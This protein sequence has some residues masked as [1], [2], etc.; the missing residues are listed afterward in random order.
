MTELAVKINRLREEYSV[1]FRKFATDCL[2]IRTKTQGVKPFILNEVQIDF[3]NRFEKQLSQRKKGRFIILKARQMGLSTLIEAIVYWRTIYH[4]GV[5]SLVLTHLDS[6]TKELFEITRRYHTSIPNEMKPKAS[7]DSANEL[8]FKGLDSAIK[9]ATAGNK[10]VGHGSTFQILHWSEVS[11]SR[12]QSDIVAGVLQA[13]PDGDGSIVF[14]ESTANG[15][16]DFFHQTWQSAIHGEN[17]YEPIFYAWFQ[18]E[19]YKRSAEGVEFTEEERSYQKLFNITDEQ[20]SWRKYIIEN[21]MGVGSYETRL[22]LF[23][24]QYPSTP[25]EAFRSNQDSFINADS[26]ERAMNSDFEAHGATIIGI[27]PARQGRDHTGVVV[28]K[29]RKVT[30]IG[31]WKIDDTMAI[32]GRAIQLIEKHQANAVFIDSIGVG[33]GVYDRLKEMGMPVHQAISSKKSE[34]PF[35]YTN[36]RAEIWA[37]MSE[38][39]EDGASIPAVEALR[40]DLLLLGY[41]YDG[42]G[43]LK[44]Q[45]KKNVN[46]SPDLADALSFT[47]YS[48]VK[49]KKE[50]VSNE[51]K[52]RRQIKTNTAIR[53]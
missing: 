37:K 36:K 14:L 17:E 27:D 52:P 50:T 16:G 44:L 46:R 48:P 35:T 6:A 51:K 32:A 8:S 31:R 40:D 5:K 30:Y 24:E 49:V 13:V 2:V 9:T 21:K 29:G 1:N 43:R 45:S 3:L 26:V 7:S 20:L 18:L 28:R 47:F 22:S 10:N 12:N 25:E 15:T 34:Q 41:D 39:L 42:N 33:A 38:W 11:R 19:D 4:K 53:F 23:K